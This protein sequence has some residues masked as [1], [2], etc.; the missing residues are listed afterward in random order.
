MLDREG[1]HDPLEH[2]RDQPLGERAIGAA[3]SVGIKALRQEVEADVECLLGGKIAGAVQRLLVCWRVG[4]ESLD[5]VAHPVVVEACLETDLSRR[6]DR[7]VED[8]G[9]GRD[10]LREPRGGAEHIAKQFA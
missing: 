7:R 9:P 8:M 4:D 1:V 6:V 5:P 3:R 2:D 10:H